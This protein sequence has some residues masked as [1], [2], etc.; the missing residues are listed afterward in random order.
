MYLIQI[1]YK[2]LTYLYLD[3]VIMLLRLHCMNYPIR[4]RI[5]IMIVAIILFIIG[6]LIG[7]YFNAFM[8]AMACLV[9]NFVAIIVLVNFGNF[10]LFIFALFLGYY[11]ALQSGF[12]VGGYIRTADD[13]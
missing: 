2:Y 12:L 4:K 1:D 8:F 6:L 7:I 10:N 9:M 13:A 11:L 3:I 5:G